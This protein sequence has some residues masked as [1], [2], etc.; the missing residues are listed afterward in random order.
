M[1]VLLLQLPVVQEIDE[2]I[3]E[4]HSKRSKQVMEQFS[5]LSFIPCSFVAKDSSRKKRR[6]VIKSPNLLSNHLVS[7]LCKTH[8]VALSLVVTPFHAF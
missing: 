8:R 4:H 3:I 1:N 5:E 6:S 2:D 7:L